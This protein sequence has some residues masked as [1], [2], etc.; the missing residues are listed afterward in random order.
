MG[1]VEQARL[2]NRTRS[3][4]YHVD[5]ESLWIE[6]RGLCAICNEPMLPNG[7]G[8]DSV[9]VEHDRSCCPTDKFS[10]GQCVRGWVHKRCNL[11]I[12]HARDSVILLRKAIAYLDSNKGR[13]RDVVKWKKR[14]LGPRAPQIRA[15]NAKR[16]REQSNAWFADRPHAAESVG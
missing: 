1:P 6:Q 8:L 11:V 5:F 15:E 12:G 10:C 2:S 7:N 4:R 16:F 13:V 9:A 3:L 14:A